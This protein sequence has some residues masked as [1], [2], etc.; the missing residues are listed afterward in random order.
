MIEQ[1]LKYA[2]MEYFIIPL[3]PGDKKPITKRG[4]KDASRDESQINEWWGKNPKANIGVVLGAEHGLCVLDVDPRNGGDE[5]FLRLTKH[6]NS[7]PLTIEVNTGGGGKHY[8]FKYDER[9]GIEN[10]FAKGVDCKKSGYVVAPPSMHISGKQYIFAPDKSFDDIPV[11]D[12]PQFLL[13]NGSQ[14]AKDPLRLLYE[15]VAEGGRNNAIARIAG[16]L[17]NQGLNPTECL[18]VALRVNEKSIPPLPEEEVRKV[19]ISIWQKHG[20]SLPGNNELSMSV[21]ETIKAFLERNIPPVEYYISNFIKKQ[22]RTMIS[23]R[24]NK[25]KSILAQQIALAISGADLGKDFFDLFE[26]KKGN[27]LYLDFEMGEPVVKD[28]F[29]KM[30]QSRLIPDSLYI[31]SMLGVDITEIKHNFKKWIE[32]FS[33]DVVVLDPIGSAWFGDENSK[34]EVTGLTAYLDSLIEKYGISFLLVH[35]HRKATD[36]HSEDGEMAAGSYKWTGWL[37]HQVILSGECKSMKLKCAKSRTGPAFEPI[38]LCLNPDTLHFEYIGP[39]KSKYTEYDLLPLIEKALQGA[40]KE[41]ISMPDLIK[42]S[43]KNHGPGKDKI[44]ELVKSS[45]KIKINKKGKTHYVSLVALPVLF[46]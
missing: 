25:G 41:E 5:S 36:S 8:Y 42:Y 10:D 39:C 24:T 15:G 30:L 6:Y 4:F 17:I 3:V 26:V 40:G 34:K 2:S 1:A 27:V 38:I 18:D 44:R 37:D 46:N 12:L 31:K 29:Q 28:R 45:E 22:G 16:A 20:S 32:Q 21:P 7:L 11:A 43:R 9:F 19:V 35:H 23:A 13:L 33:I 14:R